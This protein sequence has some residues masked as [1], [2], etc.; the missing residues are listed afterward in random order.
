M[1]F[2]KDNR[3][4]YSEDTA[5]STGLLLIKLDKSAHDNVKK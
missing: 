4:L 1:I 3:T 2:L 5:T